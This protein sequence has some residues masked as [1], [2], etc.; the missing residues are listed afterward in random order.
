VD[1]EREVLR[2]LKRNSSRRTLIE[3]RPSSFS[4][5]GRMSESITSAEWDEI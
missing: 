3:R 1:N 5:M 4:L 2:M